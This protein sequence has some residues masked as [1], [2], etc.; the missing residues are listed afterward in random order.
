MKTNITAFIKNA[1]PVELYTLAR[2]LANCKGLCPAKCK[3]AEKECWN[4]LPYQCAMHFKKWA[5]K[6]NK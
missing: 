6:E 1:G 5:I 4:E 3:E 2:Q